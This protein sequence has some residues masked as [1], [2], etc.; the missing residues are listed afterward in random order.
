[1]NSYVTIIN[2]PKKFDETN[3]VVTHLLAIDRLHVVVEGF[4]ENV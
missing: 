4:L 3:M 1:M 2:K